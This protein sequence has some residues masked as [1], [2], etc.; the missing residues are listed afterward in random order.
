MARR[1]AVLAAALAAG[2]PLAASAQF[3]LQL[4]LTGLPAP[5]LP[6]TDLQGRAWSLAALKGRVVI[7]NFW[8]TWCGP[9]K[10]EMPTLQTLAELE[11]ERV[12]VLAVNTRE[13]PATVQ[14][15]LAATQLRLPVLL[16][17]RG[18][19]TRAWQV[20]A[21]PTTV[22][23]DTAGRPR[24]VV[25]GAVDWTDTEA[26]RWIEALRGKGQKAA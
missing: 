26:A 11:A 10:E 18:E 5:A 22:L 20:D 23:I 1:R 3:R 8:A 24:I 12:A 16:D 14:R 7:V 17:P 21:F 2:L 9:C 15:Y 25:T 6:P 13:R 4:W 19:A